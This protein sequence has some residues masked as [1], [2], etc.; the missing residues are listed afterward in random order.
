MKKKMI[1]A[2]AMILVVAMMLV[3]CSSGSEQS[4]TDDST[5]ANP[6]TESDEQGVADATGF[7]VTAPEGA[8]DVAYS[9]MSEGSMAQLTYALD[10]ASWVYR[11]QTAEAM[12][13]ISGMEYEWAEQT[14]C[15]VLG[16]AATYYS[17]GEGDEIVRVIDWFDALTG[18]NYSLSATGK[19]LSCEEMQTY[20]KTVY[21]ALQ[22]ETDGETET[23]TEDVLN[24]YFIG[25]H[26]RSSDDS[27]LTISANEDGTYAV[28]LN[29]TRLCNLE[30]GVGTYDDGCITFTV[31]DP[32]ENEMSG[33]VYRDSDNTLVVKIIESTWSLL[34]ADEILDGFGK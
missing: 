34:P 8:T 32:E 28:N 11:M 26:K 24:T 16:C 19:E 22:G 33:V 5:L 30:N 9:Y 25:E 6:W 12:A 7:D 18:V 13:D 4:G 23:E 21:V 1:T 3:G 27:V 29:V 31:Q 17:N 10:D 14:D 15:D 2:L 20:A